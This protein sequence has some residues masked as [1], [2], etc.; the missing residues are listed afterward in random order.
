MNRIRSWQKMFKLLKLGGMIMYDQIL[1]IHLIQIKRV[2][3]TAISIKFSVI[4]MKNFIRF[5]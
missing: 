3:I 1:N 2:I 5:L 4:N